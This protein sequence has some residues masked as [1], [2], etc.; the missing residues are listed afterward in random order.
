MS[1]TTH[2]HKHWNASGDMRMCRL[3]L[4]V[5]SELNAVRMVCVDRVVDFYGAV[6]RRAAGTSLLHLHTG[7]TVYTPVHTYTPV[8][9]SSMEPP[10]K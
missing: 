1:P 3:Y 4:S 10:Y 8:S 5:I 2:K 9:L 6:P 7:V